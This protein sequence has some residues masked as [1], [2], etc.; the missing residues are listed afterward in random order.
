MPRC[1]SKQNSAAA[2]SDM[3]PG[4]VAGIV[5]GVVCAVFVI[6]AVIGVIVWRS[7]SSPK[8]HSKKRKGDRSPGA[9]EEG[10]AAGQS[11]ASVKLTRRN[12]RLCWGAQR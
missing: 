2:Q 10:G 3:S 9:Q 1:H 11:D 7:K 12:T 6:A 5:V 4:V 8:V